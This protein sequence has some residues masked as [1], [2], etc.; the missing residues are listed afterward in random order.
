MSAA[1]CIRLGAMLLIAAFASHAGA[2]ET[3]VSV[4]L[5]RALDASAAPLLVAFDEGDFKAAGVNIAVEPGSNAQQAIA[6]VASGEYDLG[7]ADV[8]TLIRYRDVNPMARVKAVFILTSRPAFAIIGRKSRGV[9]VPKDLE[10]RKLGAPTIDGAS[11]QWPIF[12]KLNGIDPERVKIETISAPVREPMLAAG[13]LDAIT[14]LTFSAFIDL[15]HEG[16]PL[17][18]ISVL[19]MSDYGLD[20]YGNAVIVNTDFAAAHPD[21]VRGFLRALVAGLK[22]TVR[23]PQRAVAALLKRSEGRDKVTELERIKLLL[24]ENVLT[25]DVKTD[26]LGGIDPVR[27]ARSV[28]QIAAVFPFKN[29][30]PS[31]DDMFDASF[32]PAAETRALR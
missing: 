15:K 13:Q 11:W 22:Q 6:R 14:G 18:D 23:D 24:R 7:I 26:G 32:L 20:L 31:A 19:P 2:A 12:A 17:A 25:A 27:F 29:G 1:A 21:A 3:R 30:R 10:G 4:T 28:D 16:V 9:V 5:D 8:T